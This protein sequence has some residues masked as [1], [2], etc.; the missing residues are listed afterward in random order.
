MEVYCYADLN[1][2]DDFYVKVTE[3]S[4]IALPMT[5]RLFIKLKP[6]NLGYRGFWYADC[7]RMKNF[8]AKAT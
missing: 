4:S 3:R 5:L 6:H 2:I 8:N 7:N 1:G